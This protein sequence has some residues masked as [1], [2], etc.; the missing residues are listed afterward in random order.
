VGNSSVFFKAKK[1]KMNIKKFPYSIPILF[2]DGQLHGEGDVAENPVLCGLFWLVAMCEL[3]LAAGMCGLCWLVAVCELC[4]NAGMCFEEH[5][6]ASV[7]TGNSTTI[8]C[9]PRPWLNLCAE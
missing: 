3:C 1:S 5:W 8:F 9:S 2:S 4:L 7:P 6:V